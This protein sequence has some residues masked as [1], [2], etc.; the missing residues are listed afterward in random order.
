MEKNNNKNSSKI[1]FP[2][3]SSLRDHSNQNHNLLDKI[4]TIQYKGLRIPRLFVPHPFSVNSPN[5]STESKDTKLLKLPKIIKNE[6]EIYIPIK[7]K[8]IINFNEGNKLKY[9]PK[10]NNNTDFI[11]NVEDKNLFNIFLKND[12]NYNLI[13][14]QNF[15]NISNSRLE[16]K[17][18]IN[19]NLEKI[20][21]KDKI[22]NKIN[23]INNNIYNINFP[24]FYNFNNPFFDLNEQNK[25]I[26]KPLEKQ[27]NIGKDN[28]TITFMDNSNANNQKTPKSLF[29]VNE[30]LNKDNI[31]EENNNK[32]QNTFLTNKRGRK[33]NK[34]NKKT[35]TAEDDDNILRKI[36]VHFISFI[37]NFVNDIIKE[38]SKTR[39][40]PLFKNVDYKLKKIVNHKYFQNMRSLKI[41]D[42]LQMDPSPK[43]KNHDKSVNVNIYN[44]ICNLFPF[45]NNFLQIDFVTF[46]K[47]YYYNNNNNFI[48]NGRVI[49]LS[50]RTKTFNNLIN[51]NYSYKDKIKFIA[52]NCFLG[53]EKAFDKLKFKTER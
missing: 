44:K 5:T 25:L 30:M 33:Q 7:E 18:I 45:M 19:N 24:N 8:N 13:H 41:A 28:F 31:K 34:Y 52:L 37:T 3:E 11:N 6:N 32:N 26:L 4:D 14:P 29:V 48:V 35:H 2:I 17:N 43:M 36:Q 46:F 22:Q 1:N 47:E 9:Y 50:E 20:N 23:I 38:F 42:I 39:H 53:D 16:N 27:D 21:S 12:K 49:P 40:A 15:V 10:I 51:K